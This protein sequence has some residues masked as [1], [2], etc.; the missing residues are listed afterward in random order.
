VNHRWKE[1]TVNER[2]LG[3]ISAI[4]IGAE[5]LRNLDRLSF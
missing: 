5:F 3:N 1:G 4:F 2:L